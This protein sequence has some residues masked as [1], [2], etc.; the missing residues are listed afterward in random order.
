[1]TDEKLGLGVIRV[2]TADYRIAVFIG[3]FHI[4]PHVFHRET[5]D[6]VVDPHMRIESLAFQ[7]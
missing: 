6:A 1:M 2:K 5:L 4:H 3:K 7:R